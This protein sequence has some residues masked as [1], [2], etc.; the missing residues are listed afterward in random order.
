MKSYTPLGWQEWVSFPGWDIDFIKAKVDTGAR[1]S[2]LHAEDISFFKK[3]GSDWAE[4]TVYPWQKNNSDAKTITAELVAFRKVR[5]SSGCQEKRPVVL[6][7]ISVAGITFK[8]EITLTNREL[9]GFRML[10]GRK[11]LN[12]RF[13]VITSKSHLGI[14]APEEIRKLNSG[15][16]EK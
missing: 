4:F 6:A 16:K 8:T 1:T 11:S 5:S 10:L 15:G 13:S 14:K 7:D 12:K 9:M 3:D 2:S